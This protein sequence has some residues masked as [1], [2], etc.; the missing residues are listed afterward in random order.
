[1]TRIVLPFDQRVVD[2][3]V[4][5][6]FFFIGNI[7]IGNTITLATLSGI[8]VALYNADING[9]STSN[10]FAGLSFCASC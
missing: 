7:G 6:N 2:L 8:V 9:I 3:A 10:K 5:V 4:M 1:M